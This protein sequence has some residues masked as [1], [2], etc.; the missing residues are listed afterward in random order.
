MPSGACR[1][2]DAF[3][4]SD[5]RS[6]CADRPTFA[7]RDRSAFGQRGTQLVRHIGADHP[8]PRDQ[9]IESLDSGCHYLGGLVEFY[10]AAAWLIDSEITVT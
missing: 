10:H 4:R 3:G 5:V 9:I 8:F 1:I 7:E 6:R 2:G